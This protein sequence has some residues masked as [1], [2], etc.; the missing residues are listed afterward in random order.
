M[1][2]RIN[3]LPYRL[4]KRSASLRQFTM[5]S[6]MAALAGVAI[7]ASIHGVFAGYIHS[8]NSRNAFIQAENKN[9]DV[10][11]EEIKRL[12][13]DIEMLK[14]RK[15]IIEKLQ[16][17]RASAVH[18]IGELV[19]VTPNGIYLKEI[20]QSGAK[21]TVKGLSQS[22]ELVADMMLLVGQSSFIKNP[23]LGEIKASQ[24]GERRL[25]EFTLTFEMPQTVSELDSKSKA[26]G[27]K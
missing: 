6:V 18:I 4:A 10:K 2:K 22:N 21:V 15:D 26:K 24:V 27:K 12:R 16:S 20:K 17:D 19:N 11:I 7:V 23:V 5:A 9:L 13:N 14:A 8:Q 1:I 25:N 3:L